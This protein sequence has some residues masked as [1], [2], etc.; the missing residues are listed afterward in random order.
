M[1]LK[2]HILLQVSVRC[3]NIQRLLGLSAWGADALRDYLRERVI[4]ELVDED[5]VPLITETGFVKKGTK[6]CEVERQDSGTAGRIENCQVG[7]L[8]G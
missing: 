8:L 1:I 7:V 6:S 5:G 3:K 2:L 4:A